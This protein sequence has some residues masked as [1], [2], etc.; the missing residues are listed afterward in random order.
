MQ[1]MSDRILYATDEVAFFVTNG[2]DDTVAT[3]TG[4]VDFPDARTV[5]ATETVTK[6]L[7]PDSDSLQSM[8]HSR[9]SCGI[10][11]ILFFVFAALFGVLLIAIL[12]LWWRHSR[13]KR[14]HKKCIVPSSLDQGTAELATSLPE[15][16]YK[17]ERSTGEKADG[18]LAGRG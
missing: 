9:L 15:Q 1:F 16:S 4:A 5:T 13:L 18:N 7:Y 10:A 17:A 8:S 2:P 3:V 11:A 14:A 6:Y 12:I